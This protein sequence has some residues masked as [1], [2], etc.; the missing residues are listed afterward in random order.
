MNPIEHVWGYMVNSW[1]PGQERTS[2]ELL[3][4]V[5]GEWET[6]RRNQNIIYNL[7]KSVPDRLAEVIE[8]EGGW[9]HY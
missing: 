1:T 4:H 2:L 3:H 9:T 8:N 5:M 7:V 6:L